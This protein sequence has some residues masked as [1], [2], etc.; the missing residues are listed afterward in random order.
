MPPSR[1][2][3]DF[4]LFI[5]ESR[6][7]FFVNHLASMWGLYKVLVSQCCKYVRFDSASRRTVIQSNQGTLAWI[8][9]GRSSTSGVT[10]YYRRSNC[11]LISLHKERSPSYVLVS[12]VRWWAHRFPEIRLHQSYRGS[13]RDTRIKKK[14]I[15][16]KR[17]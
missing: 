1:E 11:Y 6:I 7:L 16:S 17:S 8:M 10:C 15:F 13:K 14:N 5:G 4:V 3:L 9:K 12:V 2:T